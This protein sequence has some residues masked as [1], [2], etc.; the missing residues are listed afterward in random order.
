MPRGIRVLLPLLLLAGL[1]A[2]VIWRGLELWMDGPLLLP[3]AGIVYEVR[4]GAG[5]RT[6]FADLERR[7][8]V[9]RAEPLRW[10]LRFSRETAPVQAGEY[11]IAQGTTPRQLLQQLA[12]GQVIQY[13]LTLPEGWTLK[14]VQAAL[15]QADGLRQTLAD[16]QAIARH[17]GLPEGMSAEGW[18]FPDTYHYTRGMPDADVLRAAHRR[19]QAVLAAAWEAR[20]DGLPYADPYEVLIMASLIERETGMPAERGTIAG[21]FVRRLQRG[22]RLQTDPTVIYG[23]GDTFDGNLTRAH[24]RQPGAYNTYMIQGL[25]PTPIAMPGAESIHAAVHP[26][27]GDSLYFVARGDGSHVFSA[28][29]EAHNEAVRHYQLRARSETYR[30]S[31]SASGSRP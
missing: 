22:M 31:P 24:L 29:L 26:E 5:I 9:E 20:A 1:C 28:T 2:L 8:H 23:L 19:M 10:Y 27:P 11:R 15:H 6:V 18:I 16:A 14:Q 13:S 12:A 3:T 17:L 4:S 30:S 21:V 25:P 7:G